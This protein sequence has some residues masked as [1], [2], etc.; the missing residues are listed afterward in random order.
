MK[1][2]AFNALLLKYP[3]LTSRCVLVMHA[4]G[5]ASALSPESKDRYASLVGMVE[6]LC[7]THKAACV[8]LEVMPGSA[9][10]GQALL[11][12]ADAYFDTS[13]KQG[14]NLGPFHYLQAQ[15]TQMGIDVT[16]DKTPGTVVISE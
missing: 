14:F 10:E 15:Q 11:A 5:N 12:V 1:I 13:Y 9:L 6:E 2:T 8:R 3:D 4:I 16:E 7:T